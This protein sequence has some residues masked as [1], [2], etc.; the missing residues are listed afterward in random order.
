MNFAASN[1]SIT[2]V[3]GTLT[4]KT[5]PADPANPTSNSPQC[6]DVGVT[7]TRTGTPSASNDFHPYTYLDG[8]GTLLPGKGTIPRG[9]VGVSWGGLLILGDIEWRSDKATTA[10][11]F[12]VTITLPHDGLTSPAVCRY[13][14]DI[15][16]FGWDCAADD[17]DATTVWRSGLTQFSDW[18]VGQNVGATALSLRS[19]D[20]QPG[21]RGW[22]AWG[23]LLA[24]GAVWLFCK[25]RR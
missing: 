25:P 21:N 22:I 14:G 9:N 23:G 24:L 17:F 3:D 2:F 13:P 18:A 6:A 4:V 19:F 5:T 1:Y 10:N 20:A 11:G 8:S 7:L 15:G 16:G 12:T